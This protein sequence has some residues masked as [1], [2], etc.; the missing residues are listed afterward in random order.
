MCRKKSSIIITDC[1]NKNF[2]SDIGLINP[3]MP[4]IEWEKHHKPKIWA[5]LLVE[6]GFEVKSIQWSSPNFLGSLRKAFLENQLVSYFTLSHYRL[7][8]EREKQ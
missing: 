1:T 6:K 5:S 8:M 3:F 4:T 2:F 7:E